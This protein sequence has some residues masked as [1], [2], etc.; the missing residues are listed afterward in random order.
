MVE[1]TRSVYHV[2]QD[3]NELIPGIRSFVLDMDG[4]VYLD[5]TWIDGA[6]EFLHRIEETGRHY[7]FITNNSSKNPK[8]YLDKLHRMGLD[9]NPKTQLV[10]SGMATIDYLQRNYSG[11][12]VYLFGNPGLK[13]EFREAGIEL[14]ENH[15][16]LVVTAFSTSFDYQDLMK[17]TDL[18]RSGLP[19]IGTHPDYNCPT[20]TG[21]IPDIGS[22]HAYIKA[23]TGRMP[24]KVIG[25]PH[26]EIMDY[27]LNIMQGATAKNTAVVGDRLYT[28]IKSGVVNGLKSILVLSGEAKLEDVPHSDVKPDLTFDSVKEII[29]W[30]N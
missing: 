21:F 1:I 3:P 20:K 24:D 16:D 7:C 29:P 27:S 15:P 28:D 10:T 26:K 11:K 19:Y 30:L 13:D 12:R 17:V 4:T 14:D 5:E 8:T 2:N 25:K 18:V 9:I 6:K 22:L 23:S